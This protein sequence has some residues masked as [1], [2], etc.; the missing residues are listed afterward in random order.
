MERL[1]SESHQKPAERQVRVNELKTKLLKTR[2][3]EMSKQM[4]T[5]TGVSQYREAT[6][7][8]QN[9][10]TLAFAANERTLAA[11]DDL[12]ENLRTL[13]HFYIHRWG[14]RH[15]PKT[16]LQ[17]GFYSCSVSLRSTPSPRKFLA[18]ILLP[19]NQTTILKPVALSGKCLY[20]YPKVMDS[21]SNQVDR[22]TAPIVARNLWAKGD[23]TH[24]QLSRKLPVGNTS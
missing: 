20:S 17:T 24:G 11:I 12:P 5:D 8:F 21:G 4:P 10:K 3:G 16:V 2:I 7:L 19:T 14:R 18:W 9:F 15:T 22:I 1:R 6:I 23:A 13:I